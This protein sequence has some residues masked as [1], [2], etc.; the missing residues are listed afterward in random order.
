[1]AEMTA[2]TALRQLQQAQSGMKKARQ[3]LRLARPPDSEP[4]ARHLA[5]RVG[6]ESLAQ[7]HHLLASIPLTAATDPV[8]TRQ[9]AVQRY[10]TALLVRL[11]RLV[12]NEP[13]SP[14]DLDELDIVDEE[15]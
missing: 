10:A 11:R 13:V 15:G 12:R 9:L 6:W 3:A 14:E 5:L 4:D 7:A 1:M 8:L 2:G